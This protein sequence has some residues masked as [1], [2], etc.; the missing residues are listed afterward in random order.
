[1]GICDMQP[2]VQWGRPARAGPQAWRPFLGGLP[3]DL[4][5]QC[6]GRGNSVG[7]RDSV[8]GGSKVGCGY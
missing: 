3:G 7:W 8:T 2:C 6:S 5:V 1:M 4:A